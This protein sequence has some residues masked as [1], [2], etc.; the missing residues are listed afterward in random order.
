MEREPRGFL[1]DARERADAILGFCAGRTEADYHADDMLRAAVERNFEVIG[2][3]LNQ[4]Q[5]AAPEVAAR[6]PELGRTVAF[7]NLL[8]HGYAVVDDG[9]VWRTVQ[10]D[11]PRLRDGLAALLGEIGGAP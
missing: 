10:E 11:L 2:E 4:L 9:I 5:K 7:R 3:A 8:I 1:W 6:V